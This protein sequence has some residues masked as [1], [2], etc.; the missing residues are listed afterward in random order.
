[1][2]SLLVVSGQVTRALV[3]GLV[4][5]STSISRKLLL[6]GGFTASGLRLARGMSVGKRAQ[7]P[8][9]LLKLWDRELDSNCRV[10]RE[11]LCALDLD[12]EVR[13]CP[14]GGTRFTAELKFKELPQLED[15]N[16]RETLVGADDIL[17][18]LYAKYG[19]GRP[20]WLLNGPIART[21]TGVFVKLLTGLR[22]SRARPSKAPAQPLE[23]FGFEASPYSR[24]AR[25]ALCELELPYVLHN[26]AKGSKRRRAFIER[27]GKM[28]VPWLADPNTGWQGFES[29]I[30]EEYLHATYGL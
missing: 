11:A 18:H 2:P 23:L 5:P 14:L 8:E 13:P 21:T 27:V 22:G 9:K 10:V 6:L 29:Q 25:I 12:A 26:L 30:I 7:R 24:F 20:P 1:M 15:P 3:K 17:R 4:D 16:T 28:Q 19:V